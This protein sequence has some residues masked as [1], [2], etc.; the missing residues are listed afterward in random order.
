[1]TSFGSIGIF[2][3]VQLFGLFVGRHWVIV[4]HPQLHASRPLG[5]PQL[6]SK[7]RTLHMP[8]RHD[9]DELKRHEWWWGYAK[10]TNKD[11]SKDRYNPKRYAEVFREQF[12]PM[13]NATKEDEKRRDEKFIREVFKA[14]FI[15]SAWIYEGHRRIY[16]PE[17]PRYC[18]LPLETMRQLAERFPNK[19]AW[20]TP[21]RDHWSGEVPGRGWTEFWRVSFNLEL[22]DSVLVKEFRRFIGAARER[23]K[24][25]PKRNEGRRRRPREFTVWETSDRIKWLKEDVPDSPKKTLERAKKEIPAELLFIE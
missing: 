22:T 1:M 12:S 17:R 6:A 23:L 14:E 5:R 9:V 19:G 10:H 24:I 11:P 13:L 20:F 7:T 3:S 25:H 4:G 21:I 2:K 18:D 8:K 16:A 15:E